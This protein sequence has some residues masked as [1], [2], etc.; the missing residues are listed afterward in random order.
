MKRQMGVLLISSIL[1]L[2]IFVSSG[3]GFTGTQFGSFQFIFYY[4]LRIELSTTSERAKLTFNHT[5]PI[6]TQRFISVQGNPTKHGATMQKLWVQSSAAGQN[7]S[8]IEDYAISSQ[9]INETIPVILEKDSEGE[10][11]L[12]IYQVKSNGATKL[13]QEIHHTGGNPLVS[14]LDLSPLR[15]QMPRFG[16]IQRISPQKIVLA[17]Y[18]LW[19]N[20]WDW[21]SPLLQDYPLTPY[22]SND[23]TAL[24]RHIDQAKGAGINGF[25][26]SWWGPDDSYINHN[27]KDLLDM[28]QS[29]NF[30]IAMNFETLDY[31]S[32]QGMP[33]DEATLLQWLRYAIS[34]YGD[35]SA[36][37][38][39]NGKPVIVLWASMSVSLVT[40]QSIFSQL[41]SEG[42]DGVFIAEYGGQDPS[43]ECLEIFDG[44]HKYNI[45]G[46]VENNSEVPTLLTETYETTGR[47]VSYYP[48][49]TDTST[50]KIWTATVQ[51]GYDDH[52]IPNRTTPILL[53][54]E[55]ALYQ[56]TWEAAT[57]S[58]PDW[59]FI[60]TWNEW[61]EH[62]YIEPSELYGHQY[63]ELTNNLSN[64]WKKT[65]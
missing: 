34:N 10:T 48:L 25:I 41:R 36:F 43:L 56:A 55:G 46:I 24:A 58:N 30:S 18:Y 4:R 57:P 53:R 11:T 12:R 45:L 23:Q 14:Y 60:T 49:L 26:A 40:W 61:W 9:S 62:T 20:L 2:H 44:M 13:L 19:Y 31:S 59:I 54:E 6:L 35:H 64:Q 39:V 16:R 1:L 52:L 22:S 37:L 50:Q 8:V 3:H 27:F 17:F 38:K 32:G 63:L 33:R 51:P 42:L 47:G 29:K 15:G 21:D 65:R 5:D 7:V 28:A